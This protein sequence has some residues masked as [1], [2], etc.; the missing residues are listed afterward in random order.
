MKKLQVYWYL[1]EA[2]LLALYIG[3]FAVVANSIWVGILCGV[4]ITILRNAVTR[5]LN[6]V[7]IEEQ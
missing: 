1:G 5:A 3:F 7:K 6:K 4:G 2:V